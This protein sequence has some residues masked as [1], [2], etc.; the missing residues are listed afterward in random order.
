MGL[1]FICMT[2]SSAFIFGSSP[3]SKEEINARIIKYRTSAVTITVRDENGKSLSSSGITVEETNQKFLF[4]CNIFLWGSLD[5]EPEKRKLYRDYFAG[6]FNYATLPVYWSGYE[7]EKGKKN[8]PLISDMAMWC[9]TN[10]IRTKGHTLIWHYLV[11]LWA[12]YDVTQTENAL[13]YRVTDI[14]RNYKGLIDTFDVINESFDGAGQ[15]NC[16]GKWEKDIGPV[17]AARRALS[18]ARDANSNAIL[19]VNDY[20]TSTDYESQINVLKNLGYP[21]DAI[22]IQSHM[23]GG[24]W[25]DEQI[26]DIVERFSRY[27]IPIHFTEMT[28]LSGRLKTDKDWFSY[29]RGWD[30]TP[31]GEKLQ[32]ENAERVYRLLFSLPSVEAITWWDLSDY[33]NAGVGAWMGAPSGLLRKDMTPK[34]AYEILHKLIKK[35]WRT[36]PLYL[37]TDKNGQ[38]AF[39]GFLGLYSIKAGDR[40]GFFDISAAVDGKMTVIVR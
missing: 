33:Y 13:E 39:R 16:V 21:P 10:G 28:I 40:S 8:D 3:G 18:W 29:Q 30:T 22:G 34:P 7:I 24:V 4:G 26:L 5:N 12:D 2:L 1:M 6:L 37:T 31:E 23:H 9:K 25:P 15:D 27:N 32:A 11:P 14:V 17:E 38:A 35:E 36:G 19:I 20:R